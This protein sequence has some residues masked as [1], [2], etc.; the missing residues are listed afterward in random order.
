VIRLTD[1]RDATTAIIEAAT[2]G[3]TVEDDDCSAFLGGI[4]GMGQA[5]SDAKAACGPSPS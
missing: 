3:G 4:L 5:V 1:F 2:S